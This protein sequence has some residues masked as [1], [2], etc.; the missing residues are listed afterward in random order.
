MILWEGVVSIRVVEYMTGVGTKKRERAGTEKHPSIP[1]IT[2][3]QGEDGALL[4]L[5]LFRFHS[6]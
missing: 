4:D 6:F 5:V 1:V 2:R 3:E